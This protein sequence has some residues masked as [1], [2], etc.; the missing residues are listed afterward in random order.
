MP[1]TDPR[2][3]ST[4]STS[5]LKPISFTPLTLD[6]DT[7]RRERAATLERERALLI[8]ERADIDARCRANI[9]A[10]NSSAE[11]RQEARAKHE[12]HDADMA[13]VNAALAKI[14]QDAEETRV[15]YDDIKKKIPVP[16][17][18]YLRVPT[19]I[20]REQINSKLT[21]LGVNAVSQEEARANL[22]EAI[23]E[24]DWGARDADGA[25]D[26]AAN[27]ILADE[28][29][30]LMD[31][32]WQREGV[33]QQLVIEWQEQEVERLLDIA[34]GA[35][36]EAAVEKPLQRVISV[37][38]QAQANII[39]TE[40][41]K[42]SMRMRTIAARNL[43][44]ERANQAMLV[45]I[46]LVGVDGI[47]TR[48]PIAPS[49]Y[50]GVLPEEVVNALRDAMD[51]QFPSELAKAAWGQLVNKVN[52][53]YTLDGF[54]E[55][56]SASPLEKLPDQIGSIGSNGETTASVG[57]STGL[58]SEPLPDAESEK[59]TGRSS[60]SGPASD[61]TIPVEKLS[62]MEDL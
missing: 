8:A 12:K 20:E 45:R 22:I 37:R 56:N 43:D 40:V 49:Q 6:P 15:S 47:D 26:T 16:P 2:M 3:Q 30:Q 52:S 7:W 10:P 50:D 1:A 53:L 46:N 21:M 27:E 61:E 34:N 41:T 44:Y 17:I 32:V 59:T 42:T 55:K 51:M 48:I 28:K 31:S 14:D 18:F 62:Q 29:A 11:E 58:N 4:I 36:F 25:V 33:Q 57:N 39:A 24:H 35:P 9:L 19:S 54:E 13:R 5:A 38:E 60:D 23:Y